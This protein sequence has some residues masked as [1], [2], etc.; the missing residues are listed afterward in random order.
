MSLTIQEMGKQLLQNALKTSSFCSNEKDLKSAIKNA[1]FHKT[2]TKTK[3]KN[4]K[5]KVFNDSINTFNKKQKYNLTV[6]T[7]F[8]DWSD[9]TNYLKDEKEKMRKKNTQ[10]KVTNLN[11][12]CFEDWGEFTRHLKL[13]R[14]QS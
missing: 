12:K 3:T 10:Y 4:K 14:H 6:R 5:R 7:N 13:I 8:N 9:F 2:K 1:A 11:K